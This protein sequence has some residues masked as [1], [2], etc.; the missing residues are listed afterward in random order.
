MHVL[1]ELRIVWRRLNRRNLFAIMS[2]VLI[3]S[4]APA[5]PAQDQ[6]PPGDFIIIHGGLKPEFVSLSLKES[7]FK[8]KF[9]FEI[10]NRPDGSS[11]AKAFRD[12]RPPR[13]PESL[14]A[15]R[16]FLKDVRNVRFR[17]SKC[18]SANEIQ[19]ALDGLLKTV[20]IEK[21]NQVSRLFT[22]QF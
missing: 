13:R 15:M 6:I 20:P 4:P 10:V 1:S 8:T 2:T 5:A 22:I 16:N 21:S 3:A 9:R 12:G 17:G 18:I 11:L 14:L 7:C 19:L